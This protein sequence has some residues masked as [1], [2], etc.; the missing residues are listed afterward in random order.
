MTAIDAPK[1]RWCRVKLPRGS[2]VH[3]FK[4]NRYAYSECRSQRR[5]MNRII[6]QRDALMRIGGQ[7]YNVFFNISQRTEEL[8]PD[9]N[10]VFREMRDEWRAVKAQTGL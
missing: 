1:C 7:M 10:R 8:H 2:Y 6:K 9:D 3:V 4:R 5:C